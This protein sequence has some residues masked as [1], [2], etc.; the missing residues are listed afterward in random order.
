MSSYSAPGAHVTAM[1]R[2]ATHGRL[3]SACRPPDLVRGAGHHLELAPLV[4]G[5]ELV[6]LRDRGEAALRADRQLADV[7]VARGLLDL[8]HEL[9]ARLD[10]PVL[11]RHDPERD[12]RPGGQVAQGR[13]VARTLGLVPLDEE[14]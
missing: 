1:A 12:D 13:V 9:L 6:A 7:G 11:A 10:R 4:V 2:Q 5:R 14:D 3:R 8:A